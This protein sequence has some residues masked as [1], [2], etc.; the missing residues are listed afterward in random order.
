MW[1]AGFCLFAQALASSQG[2]VEVERVL[3]LVNGVPILASEVQLAQ[4]AGLVPRLPQEDEVS[5]QKATLEALIA[6]ELRYQDLAEAHWQERLSVDWPKAWEKVLGQAGGEEALE[7]KLASL[8][9]SKASL[10]RLLRR[11]ALVEAYVAKR[12]ASTLR[13]SEEELQEAYR[14]RF[15]PLPGTPPPLSQVRGQLEALLK[16]QKLLAEVERWTRQLAQRSEV[17]RYLR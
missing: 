9:L 3:A 7:E 17:I 1:L 8:G 12:F 16:E 13:V 14:Q 11:A 15:S 5:Y 2:P 4:V 10:E 6:L